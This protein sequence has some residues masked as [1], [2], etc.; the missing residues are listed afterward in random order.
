MIINRPSPNV[1]GVKMKTVKFDLQPAMDTPFGG[2]CSD[3]FQMPSCGFLCGKLD[4]SC[5]WRLIYFTQYFPNVIA[6]FFCVKR[7]RQVSARLQ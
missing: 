2:A 5:K 6:F 4:F 1:C 7:V 3:F